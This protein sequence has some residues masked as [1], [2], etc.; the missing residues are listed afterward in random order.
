[1]IALVETAEG[2]VSIDLDDGSVLT[3]DVGAVLEPPAQVAVALPRVQAAVASGSTIVCLLDT[4][5][6]LVV[7]HDAGRT[8][9]ESGRGLP[10]GR[11]IAVAGDN[12]DLL[13]YAASDRLYLSRDGGRFWRALAV[14]LEG[15]EAVTFT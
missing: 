10:S 4:K 6:P 2:V 13:L 15:I 14:E 5:P 9:R 11:A 8:W 3:M 12:P 1:V 7:S